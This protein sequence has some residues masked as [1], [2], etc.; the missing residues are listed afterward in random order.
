LLVGNHQLLALDLG[1]L[2]REFLIER[3]FAPRGL[4]H[5]VNFPD[6]AEMLPTGPTQQDSVNPEFLE[7]VAI[8]YE[9]RSLARSFVD[10]AEQALGERSQ[11]TNNQPRN[12][13]GDL[14][15]F[16][17]W[18]A[19]PVSPRNF[20]RLLDRREAV[21][22]FPGGALEA[23]HGTGD[24]Y[25]LFWPEQTD[26]VRAAAKFGATIVPFGAVGC[27]ENVTVLSPEMSS[28]LGSALGPVFGR[29]SRQPTQS[30]MKVKNGGLMP[31]SQTLQED[32][33]FPGVLPRLSLASQAQGGLGDRFYFSFGQ[34]VDLTE[35][36]PKDKTACG[37]VYNTLK[38][39][40][41]D[42]ITWL[43]EARTRDPYRN[44]VS[45]QAFERIANLDPSPRK[46]GAGNLKGEVV[47]S[48]GRRAPSF[49][50]GGHDHV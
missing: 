5:P 28:A 22:L 9:F 1:P 4:A 42:E 48:Y 41:E 49:P 15:G 47:Q 43:L 30:S 8:P 44:F 2:V 19:V 6:S 11:P 25:R 23:L 40:V 31:V 36:N 33:S 3:G 34:P 50:L 26:F 38:K 12:R 27:A 21:L 29:N 37:N 13:G 39:A 32:P 16:R 14:V 35:I 20:Y 7:S 45:R 46:I 24:K 10:A 18:G 17:Q